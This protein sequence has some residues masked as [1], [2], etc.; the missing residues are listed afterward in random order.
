MNDL[1]P[2]QFGEV[3][4]QAPVKILK[5]Q[6]SFLANKTSNIINGEILVSN[7]PRR[8]FIYQFNLKAPLLNNFTYHIFEMRHG[9]ELY[10]VKIF[11]SEEIKKELDPKDMVSD[12]FEDNYYE[13]KSE[14]EYQN[15]LKKIF[16]TET[17]KSVINSIIAQSEGF[18]QS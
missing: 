14:T 13:A 11:S 9:I 18:K 1:W 3:N 15:I 5:E 10:P 6:I 16:A 4:I 17:V 8:D 7:S 12:V 2:L